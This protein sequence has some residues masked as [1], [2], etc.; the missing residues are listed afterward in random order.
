MNVRPLLFALVATCLITTAGR[1]QFGAP[2]ELR[3]TTPT[4]E[5]AAPGREPAAE[6]KVVPEI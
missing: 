6:A 3:D 1:A 4:I 2:F 5:D